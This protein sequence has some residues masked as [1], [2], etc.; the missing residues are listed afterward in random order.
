[1]VV[2]AVILVVALLVAIGLYLVANAIVSD[3]GPTADVEET[4]QIE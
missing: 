3:D 2:A 4:E 1:M